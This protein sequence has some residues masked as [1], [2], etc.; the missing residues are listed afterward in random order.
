MATVP[1]L[2]LIYSDFGPNLTYDTTTEWGVSG[3]STTPGYRGQAQFFT[4]SVDCNLG[5]IRLATY[6]VSGSSL[7]NY[8]MAQDNGSGAPGSILESFT[9]VTTPSGYLTLNS[10]LDPLLTAGTQYWV[11][12]E[13]ATSTSYNGWYFNNQNVLA[14]S[15]FERSEWGWSSFG[16][17]K[18]GTFQ[19]AAVPVPEPST[20]CLLALGAINIYRLRA[21]R[22]TTIDHSLAP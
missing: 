12:M 22:R 20:A 6:H 13:P 5:F 1:G 4:P 19:V 17:T 10:V 9:N 15:A 21:T 16:P 8:F 7:C 3:A 2:T 11:C 18:A 14:N